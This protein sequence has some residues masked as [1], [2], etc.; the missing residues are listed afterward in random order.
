MKLF[1]KLRHLSTKNIT[2]AESNSVATGQRHRSEDKEILEKRKAVYKAA[3]ERNPK[4]WSG[5]IRDWS[6]VTEVWLNSPKEVRAEEQK[7]RKLA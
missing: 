7:L 4:R 3:K 1:F 2:K 6:L 5:E